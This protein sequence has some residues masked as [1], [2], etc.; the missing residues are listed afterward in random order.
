ML[1]LAKLKKRDSIYFKE[2]YRPQDLLSV[3]ILLFPWFQPFKTIPIDKHIATY[4]Y[5]LLLPANDSPAPLFQRL[6]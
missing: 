2:K 3:I 6:S 1:D 5:R 4:L